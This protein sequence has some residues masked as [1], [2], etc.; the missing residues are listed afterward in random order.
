MTQ[1]ESRSLGL[2][3]GRESS[4]D[5]WRSNASNLEKQGVSVDK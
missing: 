5:V 3:I 4:K 1:K 2:L